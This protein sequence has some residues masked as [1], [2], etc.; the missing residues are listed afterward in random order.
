[1]D[2]L[3]KILERQHGI[4]YI[5]IGHI[6]TTL[7]PSFDFKLI[8]NLNEI[9]DQQFVFNIYSCQ[10]NGLIY[11]F[12]INNHYTISIWIQNGKTIFGFYF[13]SLKFYSQDVYDLIFNK[14]KIFKDI[15]FYNFS[16]KVQKDSFSCGF[17]CILF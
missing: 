9:H 7:F 17:Y 2:T 10:K 6:F 14:I 3:F 13:D 16:S 15:E 5:C 12:L 1:M 4:D 8:T 11:L